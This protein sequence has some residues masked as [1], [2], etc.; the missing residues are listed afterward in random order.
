MRLGRLVHLYEVQTILQRVHNECP[1]CYNTLTGATFGSSNSS[2]SSRVRLL[3][4]S[5]HAPVLLGDDAQ[6][7]ADSEDIA[8]TVQVEHSDGG[9][10]IMRKLMATVHLLRKQQPRK[11]FIDGARVA[12]LFR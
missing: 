2:S 10:A 8:A 12:L 6:L 9:G 11:Q 4:P 1:L 7:L 5:S 3:S